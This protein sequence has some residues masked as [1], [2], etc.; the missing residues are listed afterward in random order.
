MTSVEK[1]FH[2][3]EVNL[4]NGDYQL[5]KVQLLNL[6]VTKKFRVKTNTSEKYN[7]DNST[8]SMPGTWESNLQAG[9]HF[10]AFIDVE[11]KVVIALIRHNDKN[12]WVEVPASR[13]E[14]YYI[15]FFNTVT[16]NSV[17]ESIDADFENRKNDI[18]ENLKKGINIIQENKVKQRHEALSNF[19]DFIKNTSVFINEEVKEKYQYVYKSYAYNHVLNLKPANSNEHY[20]YIEIFEDESGNFVDYYST[21][22][23]K[24]VITDETVDYILEHG[25]EVASLRKELKKVQDVFERTKN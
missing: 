3:I 18:L 16:T 4:S 19:M 14:E 8:V 12:Q 2:S 6:V 23:F 11:R 13:K 5:E 1:L 21:F 22:G 24:V 7:F 20:C 9:E 25:R 15:D 17:V 10:K